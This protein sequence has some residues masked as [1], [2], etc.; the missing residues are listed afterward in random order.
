MKLINK[1]NINIYEEDSILA[2]EEFH[3][4]FISLASNISYKNQFNERLKW[5]YQQIL[6]AY[7]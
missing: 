5:Y 3:N 7:C 6:T 4:I 2:F 1:K